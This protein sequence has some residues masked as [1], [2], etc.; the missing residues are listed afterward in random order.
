MSASRFLTLRG[1]SSRVIALLVALAMIAAGIGFPP[2]LT[3]DTAASASDDHHS[4]SPPCE[5]PADESAEDQ[6]TS[7]GKHAAIVGVAFSLSPPALQR[8][9]L[10]EAAAQLPADTLLGFPSIRGPPGSA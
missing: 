4:D 2:V 5:E 8:R 10:A 3:A 7:A 9:S 6:E 1:C